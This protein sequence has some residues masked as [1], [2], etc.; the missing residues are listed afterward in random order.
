MQRS[1]RMVSVDKVLLG[2]EARR[3]LEGG[4]AQEVELE[5]LALGGNMAYRP[6]CKSQSLASRRRTSPA[7]YKVQTCGCAL[8]TTRCSHAVSSTGTDVAPHSEL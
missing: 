6:V 7:V 2:A 5:P 1:R 3:R 8:G 4:A